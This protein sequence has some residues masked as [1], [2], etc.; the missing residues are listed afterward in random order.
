[1]MAKYVVPH[2]MYTATRQV[3]TSQAAGFTAAGFLRSDDISHQFYRSSGSLHF[4]LSNPS[5]SSTN[6]A[7]YW[8]GNHRLVGKRDAA[9][10]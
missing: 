4:R 9:N 2:T 10:F 3:P 7:L 1:L 8:P 5:L 6:L